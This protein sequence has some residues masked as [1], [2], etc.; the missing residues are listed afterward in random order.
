[1]ARPLPFSKDSRDTSDEIGQVV[2]LLD[3]VKTYATGGEE[4]G[5]AAD[6]IKKPS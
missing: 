1:M 4:G 5:T 3:A 6:P 2:D